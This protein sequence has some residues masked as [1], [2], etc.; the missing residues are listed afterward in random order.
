MAENQVITEILGMV[1]RGE[2]SAE[3]GLRLI[4]AVENRSET[5]EPAEAVSAIMAD[6]Q[7][8]PLPPLVSNET[9][10]EGGE[11]GEPEGGEER[12]SV[13]YAV[14]LEAIST[15]EKQAE[16]TAY[17]EATRSITRWKRWW[18]LPFWIG[19][20]ILVVGAWWMYLG[21]MAAGFGW[22]FW[23]SWFPFLFGL[24]I[25]VAAWSSSTARWLHV[26][27]HPGSRKG[28]G[29][30]NIAI[31][32]P[33]PL[34]LAGWFIRTFGNY[35]PETR[36]KNLHEVIEAIDQALTSKDPFYVHVNDDDEE[37]EVFIG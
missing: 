9:S 37:V 8:D 3:E 32:M 4:N 5:G 20:A 7:I 24:L 22:G 36:G 33:L 17:D 16:D 12:S 19:V 10:S 28:K 30:P 11:S 18:Q 29:G 23:L 14:P 15:S 13:A 25:M 1:E 21:Y 27:V 2:I 34:R 26:R 35:I 6:T 31:S